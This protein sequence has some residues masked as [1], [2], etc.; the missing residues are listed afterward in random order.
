MPY[1]GMGNYIESKADNTSDVIGFGDVGGIGQLIYHTFRFM[2]YEYEI[3]AGETMCL[4]P[5]VYKGMEPDLDKANGLTGKELFRELYNLGKKINDF[6]EENPFDELIIEFCKEVAHPYDIDSLY[7]MVANQEMTAA[8]DGFMIEREG[9][10]G[11]TDF[12]HDLKNLYTAAQFYFALK[13]ECAGYSEYAFNLTMEGKFFDG[14]PFFEKYK[15]NIGV[16]ELEIDTK[17]NFKDDLLKEMRAECKKV[18]KQTTEETTSFARQPFDYFDKLRGQLM[19]IIPDFRMR[20]KVNPRNNAVIFAADVHSVF[21]IAWYTL[22]RMIVDFG[23]PEDAE[24]SKKEYEGTLTTC[25]ICGKAFIRKNN[26]HTYCD[27]VEC[28]RA[29]AAQRAKKS[30]DKLKLE[31]TIAKSRKI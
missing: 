12:M 27:N 9:M 2:D 8:D 17:A 20:L 18:A 14:L 31:V 19:D 28:K 6:S 21:D 13:A 16:E 29:Y 25:P 1:N 30:R 23:P 22:A 5:I 4:K 11:V 24:Q 7:S 15:Q 10:F 26:R 3:A